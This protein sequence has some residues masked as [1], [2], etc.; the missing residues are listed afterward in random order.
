MRKK[1][2][3]FGFIVLIAGFLLEFLSGAVLPGNIIIPMVYGSNQTIYLGVMAIG[4]I[5]SI[6]GLF[7]K[8]K[9]KEAAKAE[10]KAEVKAETK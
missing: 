8:K 7:L 5:I 9:G 1:F 10:V 3:V 6:M 2:I 4:A